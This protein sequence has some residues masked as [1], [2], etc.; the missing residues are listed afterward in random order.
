MQAPCICH[1]FQLVALHIDEYYVDMTNIIRPI[2]LW[3]KYFIFLNGIV[4]SLGT[5][6]LNEY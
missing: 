4:T 2:S 3:S 5:K 6:I 1:M